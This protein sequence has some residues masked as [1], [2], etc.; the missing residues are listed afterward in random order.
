MADAHLRASDAERNEVVERLA[1]H[2]A[3]GRLDQ[4]EYRAR[5]DRAMGATTRGDLAGL[6]DDLPPLPSDLLGPPPRR[7]RLLP[8]LAVVLLVALAASWSFPFV[9]VPWLLFLVV[10]LIVW[11]RAGRHDDWSRA[12]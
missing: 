11:H 2:F 1:R 5:V 8:V 3:D 4:T 9:H 7:R 12:R 6:F 10:G